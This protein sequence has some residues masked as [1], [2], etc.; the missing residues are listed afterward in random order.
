MGQVGASRRSIVLWQP[1]EE[2]VRQSGRTAVGGFIFLPILLLLV[3]AALALSGPARANSGV[4]CAATGMESVST[5]RDHYQAGEVA[6]ISGGGF[7][8]GCDVQVDVQRPDGVVE[9]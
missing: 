6:A 5:P 3:A 2:V 1:G 8:A 4:Q 9:S 7:A